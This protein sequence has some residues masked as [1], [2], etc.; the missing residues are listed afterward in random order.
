MNFTMILLIFTGVCI[1][2]LLLL[3]LIIWLSD[4]SDTK[5]EEEITFFSGAP[6]CRWCDV[7]AIGMKGKAP[8]CDKH[9]RQGANYD[10]ANEW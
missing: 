9:F 6:K 5:T 3:F 8:L 2:I 4:N 1:F 10:T 7:C